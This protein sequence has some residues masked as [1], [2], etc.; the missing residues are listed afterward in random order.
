MAEMT[1]R[2]RMLT[3]LTG[4]VPDRLPATTHHVMLYF[5]DKYL[6]GITYPEFYDRYG[7]DALLWTVP[8]KADASK[9]EY[10]D[11]NQTF[12]HPLDHTHRVVSDNW[13]IEPEPIPGQEYRTTRYHFVTPK[14][15]LSMVLQ[16]N[17]YTDW[18]VEP[19]VKE[20]NDID[21][22]AEF[23]TH[24]TCDV[25]AVN[26][27][28][29]SF[30]ERG[31]VRG[32]IC[33]FDIYGQPGCWQDAVELIGTER[34]IYETYDDPEW[35]HA[36]IGILQERKKTFIRS[37]KGAH[38]DLLELGGG[39]ASSTV[40]SPK[41][42]DEFVAP[43]DKELIELAH[44]VGQRIVYHTCGGMMPILERIADMGP[45]A[46][47]TFTPPN[48]GGDMRLAEAKQR[49]GDRVCMIGGFDQG[50]YFQGCTPEETR[51]E[52]RRCFEQAGPHGGYILSPSD[53]FF[54]ADPDLIAAFADEA[55]RCLYAS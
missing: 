42:F 48:M 53:H 8:Y 3:A 27:R 7:L 9:G 35:I 16:G 24:P 13:R 40:I 37:L 38:Y 29:E 32:H 47:E 22:I 28:A 44:S 34:I 2:Q 1:S 18:V 23:V 20:K 36:L 6:D 11:P 31:L 14:G 4:G 12:I 26:R 43:Y 46:M 33:Y 30:G 41:L 51:A 17:E 39:A 52:V 55:R 49:I 5:L 21:L 50:H 45:D 25:E 54:D 15:T 10:F 19:L